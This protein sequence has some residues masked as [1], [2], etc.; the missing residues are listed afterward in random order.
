MLIPDSANSRDFLQLERDAAIILQSEVPERSPSHSYECPGR[1]M[2]VEDEIDLAN[3]TADWLR[4]RDFAVDVFHDGDEALRQIENFKNLYDLLILDI[5]LPGSN[6]LHLCKSYRQIAGVAPILVLTAFDSLEMKEK[7]FELGA[8]DYLTKPFHLKELT[9]RAKALLRRTHTV[10]TSMRH[11]PLEID[12]A[13]NKVTFEGEHV[14]LSPKEFALLELFF[15]YP[16]HCFTQEE[17]M[18]R[19]WESEDVTMQ[20]TLR[21]HIKRLRRKFDRPDR[22]SLITNVYGMGYKLAEAL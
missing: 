9:L 4:K 2:L 8:D 16:K 3:L 11:G 22:P 21:G 7:A 13:R 6:G 18:K 5:L 20:D 12:L 17:L 1:I 19:I 14:H 15:R 10:H